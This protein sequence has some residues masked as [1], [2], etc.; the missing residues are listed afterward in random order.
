MKT[1]VVR[2]LAPIRWPLAANDC[3]VSRYAEVRYAASAD[4]VVS[5]AVDFRASWTP[6]Q[7]AC[8][9]EAYR[10][11]RIRDPGD[12][13]RMARALVGEAAGVNGACTQ[14]ALIQ[15]FATFFLA[16]SVRLRELRG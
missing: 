7:L 14:G 11:G 15:V 6:R 2:S 1:A 5:L 10:P 16:A 9:P 8:I 12:V 13:D 4:E 3:G